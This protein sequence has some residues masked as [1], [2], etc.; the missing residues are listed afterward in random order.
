MNE[1]HRNTRS[2]DVTLTLQIG[3]VALLVII[4]SAQDLQTQ[5]WLH[6]RNMHSREFSKSTQHSVFSEAA[7]GGFG[8]TFSMGRSAFG[9]IGGR[10]LEAGYFSSQNREHS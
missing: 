5:K 8:L 4:A 1:G 9:G 3:H 2:N 6:G 7:I 10:A